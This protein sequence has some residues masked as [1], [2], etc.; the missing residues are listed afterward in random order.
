M[1]V[2]PPLVN[3]P[4]K[5][6]NKVQNIPILTPVKEIGKNVPVAK[7]VNNPTGR[8]NKPHSETQGEANAIKRFIKNPTKISQLEI[9][10]NVPS[11][12]SSKTQSTN[13]RSQQQSVAIPPTN[14]KTK[15]TSQTTNPNP[16]TTSQTTNT[17]PK[18]TSQTTNTKSKTT[19]QTTN[20]K[21]TSQTTN[22]NPNT[23]SQTTNPKTTSQTTNTKSNTTLQTTNTKSNTTLQTTNPKTQTINSKTQKVPVAVTSPI[24]PKLEFKLPDRFKKIQKINPT[25]NTKAGVAIG[26]IL[27]L[28]IV[29]LTLLILT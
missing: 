16:K 29:F 22:T 9:P 6:E 23:T 18:T 24:I 2:N 27:V 12:S 10:A 15:T 7:P 5:P 26:S 21:T 11:S 8:Q 28:I 13:S 3:P 17:N 4:S 14:P 25:N 20:P 19:S 1:N